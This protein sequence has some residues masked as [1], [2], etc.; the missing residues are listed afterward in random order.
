MSIEVKDAAG[1]SRYYE[2]IEVGDTSNPFQSVVP[3]Y[4]LA[5]A[6]K[7]IKDTYSDDVSYWESVKPLTKFG[8][9]PDLDSGVRETIWMTGGD[10]TLKTA[11]D[12]D[13][14]VSTNAGDTQNIVIQGYTISGSDL[15]F[16]SQ[17]AT[18]NGTTNVTLTTPLARVV[19]LYNDDSTDFAGTIT[20][21]DNGTSTHLTVLGGSGQNQ[22]FKT[23]TS[24]ASDEYFVLTQI[25]GG[26]VGTISASVDYELQLR[27]SGKVWRTQLE[28]ETSGYQEIYLDVPK[29]FP[30]NSDIRVVATSDTNNTEAT[31]FFSGYYAK[32]I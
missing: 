18:L 3:D 8:K 21:E 13:I 15:T 17:T 23:Q 2:T 19:R 22:S 7:Y 26:V 12:I 4:R 10:E 29:I 16:V 20:V 25:G 24:V 5:L 11:N 28:F 1:T 27:L 31:A 14:V 30:P 9:N 32:V 6:V